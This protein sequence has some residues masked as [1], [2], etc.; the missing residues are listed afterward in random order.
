MAGEAELEAVGASRA[1]GLRIV[2]LNDITNPK[3]PARSFNCRIIGRCQ[4]SGCRKLRPVK[5]R[6]AVWESQSVQRQKSHTGGRADLEA[7]P[8]CL[9]PARI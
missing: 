6:K 8:G 2:K 7:V 1:T 4:R 3:R 9:E 5:T